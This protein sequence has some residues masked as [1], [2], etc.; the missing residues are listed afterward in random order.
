MP[1]KAP[2]KSKEAKLLAA[3]SS[4]KSKGKKSG[5]K[6]K[7]ERRKTIALY[8]LKLS[9]TNFLERFPKKQK[10]VT[11]YNLIEAYKINGALARRGIQELCAR[12]L[13]ITI[14]PD[15]KNP[16]YSGINASKE[17]SDRDKKGDDEGGEKKKGK[18]GKNVGGGVKKEKAGKKKKDEGEGEE[19]APAAAAPAPAAEEAPAAAAAAS[20][21]EATDD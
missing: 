2:Q 7:S 4:S 9:G 18:G 1:P 5:R 11:I 14:S 16:I 15:A 21:E 17:K 6:E 10:V 3:Q 12:G 13:L 8:L 20:T 19:E